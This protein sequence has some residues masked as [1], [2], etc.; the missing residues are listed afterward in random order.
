[1]GV[2]CRFNQRAGAHRS[3]AVIQRGQREEAKGRNGKRAR[4]GV[5]SMVVPHG[6]D[7][8]GTW[9]GPPSCIST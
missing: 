1:M 7:V 3:P 4:K 8:I 6:I 2:R 5:V 9:T